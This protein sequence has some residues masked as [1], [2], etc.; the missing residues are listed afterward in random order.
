M[1]KLD[2]CRHDNGDDQLNRFFYG[3]C[4]SPLFLSGAD[5]PNL[6]YIKST[7]L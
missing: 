3:S 2:H 6:V 4:I 1:G 5:P 7:D